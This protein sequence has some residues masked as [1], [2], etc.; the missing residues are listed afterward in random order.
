MNGAASRF[1]AG[2]AVGLVGG[3]SA[4]VDEVGERRLP[5]QEFG[6]VHRPAPWPG[7]SVTNGVRSISSSAFSQ[8][9]GQAVSMN[10]TMSTTRSPTI[11][12]FALGIVKP[13]VGL[14]RREWRDMDVE[15]AA[16]DLH[17]AATAVTGR[18][19]RSVSGLIDRR[20]RPR[21]ICAFCSAAS[22]GR[23]AACRPASRLLL[24][25]ADQR[26]V[27]RGRRIDL[28]LRISLADV[29]IAG[30]VIE[31]PVGVDD[32]RDRPAALP[33]RRRASSRCMLGM[34]PGVDHDQPVR[35]VEEDAVAVRPLVER[36][37]ARD[38]MIGRP[39]DFGAA[40]LA[41]SSPIASKTCA[42]S[43]PPLRTSRAIQVARQPTESN[44]ERQSVARLCCIAS[45]RR[46]APAKISAKLA[47]S[48]RSTRQKSGRFSSP[49]NG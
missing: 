37:R 4:A 1:P 16:G 12:S 23:P 32:R 8:P 38:Q 49:V 29:E 34:A 18:V 31:V 35:R 41:S 21:R 26:P 11:A 33:W 14:G 20:Q 9:S 2:D 22:S 45:Q 19:G 7:I 46:A 27:D 39:L 40:Q 44:D 36:N 48:D 24:E 5:L 13:Q 15:L 25:E 3:R 6:A 47:L 10:G 43:P 30:R 17:R 28:G 42:S